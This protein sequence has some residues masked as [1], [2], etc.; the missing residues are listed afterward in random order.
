[1]CAHTLL[2]IMDTICILFVFKCKFHTFKCIFIHVLDW[3]TYSK[4]P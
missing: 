1:M 4:L 3:A 2:Y